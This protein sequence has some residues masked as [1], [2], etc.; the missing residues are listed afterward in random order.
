M[1]T[2]YV[3]GRIAM[4]QSQQA[5]IRYSTGPNIQFSYGTDGAAEP[6]FW[7]ES[8]VAAGSPPPPCSRYRSVWPIPLLVEGLIVANSTNLL[9]TINSQIYVSLLKDLYMNIDLLKPKRSLGK[10]VD[11]QRLLHKYWFHFLPDPRRHC[12]HHRTRC[13]RYWNT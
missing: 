3:L 8:S 13:S 2:R 11:H 6:K 9:T 4:S 12:P 1:K 5:E 7:P 10:K